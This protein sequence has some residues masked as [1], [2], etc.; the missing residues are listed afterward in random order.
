VY[1]GTAAAGFLTSPSELHARCRV[2]LPD[3][4]RAGHETQII[5]LKDFLSVPVEDVHRYQVTEYALTNVA[6]RAREYI[7]N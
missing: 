2:G 3:L 4:R 1:G 7:W 6:A 5:Y